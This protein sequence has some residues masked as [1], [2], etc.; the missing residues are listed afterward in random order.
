MKDKLKAI[1]VGM[2]LILPAAFGDTGI[3]FNVDANYRTVRLGDQVQL[4]LKVTGDIL[5]NIVSGT[6]GARLNSWDGEGFQSRYT[7]I[8][9]KEGE[10]RF[11]PYTLSINGQTL[12]SQPLIIQVLPK[13]N[14]EYG[15]FFRID[16]SRIVLGE[17]VELVQ[18]TWS[19]KRIGSSATHSLMK[20]APK[21]YVYSIGGMSSSMSIS[22]GETNSSDRQAWLI[23]PKRSGVF[24]ITCDL[25]ESL[26]EG[27]TPPDF[28]VT[29]DES[30]QQPPPK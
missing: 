12:T 2:L 13:W 30:A 22:G 3:V 23:Q 25:F 9:Q 24:K 19:P 16:R 8:P 26:P 28:S 17:K 5:T 21:D 29:V 15:V 11:G 1:M 20:R 7:F 27:A 18:E 4:T 10:C 6:E 14:G